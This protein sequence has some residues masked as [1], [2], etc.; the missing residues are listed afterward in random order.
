[1]LLLRQHIIKN[2]QVNKKLLDLNFHAGNSKKYKVENILNNSVYAMKEKN[3]LSG[4]YN[5]IKLKDYLYNKNIKKNL[6]VVYYLKNLI[7]SF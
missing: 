2:N 7:C 4:I 6:S 1:M 3:H 5:L